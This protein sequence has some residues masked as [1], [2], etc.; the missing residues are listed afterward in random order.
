M[1]AREVLKALPNASSPKLVYLAS[2]YSN[3]DA[4]LVAARVMSARLAMVQ[5]MQRGF[6]VFSPISHGHD[7]VAFGMDAS[8]EQW[9]RLDKTILSRCDAV[10]ILTLPGW[11]ESNGVRHEALIAEETGLPIALIDPITLSASVVTNLDALFGMDEAPRIG[12]V[13]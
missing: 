12:S 13:A 9:S 1:D 6:L 10:F 2:P 11:R 5:L 4:T 7:L 3:Q 8:W